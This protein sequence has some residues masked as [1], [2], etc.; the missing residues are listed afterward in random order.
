MIEWVNIISLISASIAMLY[1][2][3]KSVRPA[4]LEKKIGRI[5]YKKC[6]RYRLLASG[7]EIIVIINYFGY[8]LFP[9]EILDLPTTFPWEW[10]LS[11]LFA[12]IISVPAFFL[13]LKG[14][15]DAGKEAMFPQEE[16]ILYKGIYQKIRHPQAVGELPLW[17]SIALLLNSPFLAIYS[18]IWIP[19][20]FIMMR[21]E[22]KDLLI[23]F[24]DVYRQYMSTTG[25]IFPKIIKKS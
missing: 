14:L 23:R 5:A 13:M 10:G 9:L 25:M 24:G 21:E 6:G 8:F 17:W 22:E 1:L 12:I 3:V 11:V 2:Y 16:Q 18:F 15:S 20:F 7:T 4:T 19:I